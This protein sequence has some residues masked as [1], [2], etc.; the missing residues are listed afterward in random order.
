MYLNF[1]NM[2]KAPFNVTPDPEFLFLSPS[3]KEALAAVIYGVQQKKGFVAIIGEVGVGKT[4]ILRSFLDRADRER[5]KLLYLFNANIN[6]STLL[7]SVL[8]ELGLDS[9]ADAPCNL[10]TRLHQYLISEYTKGRTV[11]LIID[12]AQNMPVETLENLRMLS[13]LETTKDKLIQIVFSAQPE[14]EVLLERKELRQLKQRI[15]VKTTIKPLSTEESL[16]YIRHRLAKAAVGEHGIFT[17]RALRLIVSQSNGIPRVINTLCDNCLITSFGY[18]SKIVSRQIVREIV[19]DSEFKG[20]RSFWW[21][22]IVAVSLLGVIAFAGIY[23]TREAR[24]SLV[25]PAAGVITARTDGG[26]QTRDSDIEASSV[27]AVEDGA[28]ADGEEG[29]SVKPDKITRLVKKGDTL[30]KLI[31]DTYGYANEKVF[32]Q[33]KKHNP[34]IKNAD[35]IVVGERIIFPVANR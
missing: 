21:G 14:F 3:H 12:E 33:V 1:F 5:L 26:K 28:A 17:E 8:Q 23:V 24:S 13:N 2:N 11:V 22:Q 30:A 32:E 27:L 9:T 25:K 10:V 31:V 34:G 16:R 29:G 4:T 18:K 7:E 15:A 6:F 19:A 35:R 20:E